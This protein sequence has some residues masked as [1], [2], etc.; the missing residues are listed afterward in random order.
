MALD[1][2]R[3]N[4]KAAAAVYLGMSAIFFFAIFYAAFNNNY[5]ITHNAAV[6]GNSNYPETYTIGISPALAFAYTWSFARIIGLILWIGLG[7]YMVLVASDMLGRREGSFGSWA[8]QNFNVV[9]ITV[10]LLAAIAMFSSHSNVAAGNNTV[11][12][13]PEVYN[14]VI[15]DKDKLKA[16]FDKDKLEK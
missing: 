2:K 6:V 9:T 8:A 1:F 13:T 7:V 11:T 16:L 5:P 14:N 10:G 12:V 4:W 3:I 15:D